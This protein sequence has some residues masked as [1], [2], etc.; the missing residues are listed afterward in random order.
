MNVRWDVHSVVHLSPQSYKVGFM[1]EPQFSQFITGSYTW[2]FIQIHT[3]FWI[4]VVIWTHMQ[5]KLWHPSYNNRAVV[6]VVEQPVSCVFIVFF[7]MFYRWTLRS[8]CC[9]F[10]ILLSALTRNEYWRDQL[11]L[12]LL[13]HCNGNW[14][15]GMRC[16]GTSHAGAG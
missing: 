15:R 12:L 6:L 5:R 4:K 14:M 8:D 9:L 2:T 13:F 1:T 16:I 7:N 11:Y 10:K 3:P